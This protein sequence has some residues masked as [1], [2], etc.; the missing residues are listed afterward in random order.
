MRDY[1]RKFVEEILPWFGYAAGIAIILIGLMGL[2][3]NPLQALMLCIVGPIVGGTAA[4]VSQM[5]RTS[6]I[7]A[8]GL[9]AVVANI[10]AGTAATHQLIQVLRGGEQP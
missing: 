5:A 4:A 8:E 1:A 7:T 6:R 3:S 9:Q 2:T 10:R